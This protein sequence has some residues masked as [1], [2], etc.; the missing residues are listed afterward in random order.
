MPEGLQL[1]SGGYHCKNDDCMNGNIFYPDL[2]TAWKKCGELYECASILKWTN[3][4]FALRRSNDDF[5]SNSI[6]K[7][8]EYKCDGNKIKFSHSF[9][10]LIVILS[11]S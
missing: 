1:K 2:E 7:H 4:Q 6:L 11:V 9:N 8:V 3:G 5:D 10:L